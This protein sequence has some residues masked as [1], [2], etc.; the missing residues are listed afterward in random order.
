MSNQG[1][2]QAA[3]RT[4]HAQAGNRDWNGDW[5]ELFDQEAIAGGTFNERM[6]V[7]L[8]AELV[9]DGDLEAPYDT[10]PGA[11]QAYAAR[12]GAYNWSSMTTL[13]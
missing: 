5:H 1:A 4:R 6:L 2:I 7:W 12:T 9:T 8:N 10:L 11:M 13:L 3:V